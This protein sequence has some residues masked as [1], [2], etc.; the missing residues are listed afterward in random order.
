MSWLDGCP[1]AIREGIEQVLEETPWGKSWKALGFQGAP[2]AVSS[3][4]VDGREHDT[5]AVEAI[6]RLVGAPLLQWQRWAVR[7]E[8]EVLD[9]GTLA[10]S[11]NVETLQRQL[12]K[13]TLGRAKTLRRAMSST[14][15]QVMT[16]QDRDAARARF[17]QLAQVAKAVFTH[18]VKYWESNSHEKL[19]WIPTGS[20][21]R[22]FAPKEGKL[23]GE[24]LDGVWVDELW[25]MS[26]LVSAS[27]QA[28]FGPAMQ[29]RAGFAQTLLTSTRGPSGGS[30]L[31]LEVAAGTAS[32]TAGEST[33]TS[34]LDWRI[35]DQVGGMNLLDLPTD[36]LLDLVWWWHPGKDVA[37]GQR[38]LVTRGFLAAEYDTAL[39]NPLLGRRGWLR[40]YGNW[41]PESDLQ[42]WRVVP[43]GVWVEARTTE[44]F[45][46]RPRAGVLGVGVVDASTDP[47][48]TDLRVAVVAG[49]RVTD[50]QVMTELVVA[51]DRGL[52]A[53]RPAAAV[54]ADLAT[55]HRLPVHVLADTPEGRNLADEIGSHGVAVE[56]V[57]IADAA[58]GVVRV[59]QGLRS[60]EIVHRG[61]PSLTESAQ[62]ADLP[63]RVWSGP[64]SAPIRALTAAVWGAGRPPEGPQ[65]RF[66]ILVPGGSARE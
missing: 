24:T 62:V 54:I 29:T 63:G 18:R 13:T 66:R 3:V 47:R 59:R 42:G 20:T 31:S 12:G 26:E 57:A 53:Y 6:S 11:R 27:L 35:P 9:D 8:S 30:W 43:Y 64:G 33:G 4:P 34:I 58:A 16:A 1:P 15:H 52:L 50:A 22:P 60:R 39:K 46:A 32:V 36:V 17:M 5:E 51:G 28:S 41:S 45:P 25:A 19:L 48:E 7:V 14:T 23:D 40:S 2:P 61:G 56:R 49:C 10:Y 44:E 37:E 65:G 55:R 21:I 38:P